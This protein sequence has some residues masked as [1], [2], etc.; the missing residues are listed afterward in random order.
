VE[1][2]TVG[3]QVFIT[4]GTYERI[5]EIAGVAA[6]IA[7]QMKGLAE[8]LALF[9]LRSLDGRYAQREVAAES[10]ATQHVSVAL[11]ITCW[12]IEGK[13]VGEDGIAGRV[14]RLGRRELAACLDAQLAPLTNVKLRLGYPGAGRES[15]DIY[16]KVMG[17]E[18]GETRPVTR[19][20]FTSVTST[21]AEAVEALVAAL[22]R[23]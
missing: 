23:A 21:D 6:P 19:I 17:E 4:A 5:R 12:V 10:D 8:S 3:G 16:G 1:G 13:V 7:V 9:E 20:H 15:G 18:P 11:P 14:V 22:V 2:A